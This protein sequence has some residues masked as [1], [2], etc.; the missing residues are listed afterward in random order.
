MKHDKGGITNPPF[1]VEVNVCKSVIEHFYKDLCKTGHNEIGGKLVGYLS[2]LRKEDT[3][4]KKSLKIKIV[5]YI[6][7]GIKTTRTPS[8]LLSDAEFQKICFEEVFK[9]DPN[10]EHLG[11]WHSHHSNGLSMLSK[12]DIEGYFYNVNDE[13]HNNDFFLTPL[14]VSRP[15]IDNPSLKDILSVFKMFFFIRGD[16]HFYRINEKDVKIVKDDKFT[17]PLFLAFQQIMNYQLKSD[18]WYNE[19]EGRNLLRIINTLYS[20]FSPKTVL[21]ENTLVFK[22]S[23]KD[24]DLDEEIMRCELILPAGYKSP[25]HEWKAVIENVGSEYKKVMSSQN[26]REVILYL[27]NE[28]SKIFFDLNINYK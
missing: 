9:L 1:N 2:H 18:L 10:L 28:L 17:L 27:L 20:Q 19:E 22:F 13:K 6:P 23:F 26:Y 25:N 15:K 3:K 12:T 24:Q 4:N 16:D 11:S 21:R 14:A 7:P 8:L 5:S